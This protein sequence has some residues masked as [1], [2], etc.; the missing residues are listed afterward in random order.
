MSRDCDGTTS[1]MP[2]STMTV[3]GARA[4]R[5]SDNH[6]TENGSDATRGGSS[7]IVSPLRPRPTAGLCRKLSWNPCTL[8][9]TLPRVPSNAVYPV[10]QGLNPKA[11]A[12]GQ[13]PVVP[14][15]A[16]RAAWRDLLPA[17]K[18]VL[19]EARSLHAALRALVGTTAKPC[20]DFMCDSRGLNPSAARRWT[21][22]VLNGRGGCGRIMTNGTHSQATPD[23][24]SLDPAGTTLSRV[25]ALAPAGRRPPRK[26]LQ[27][28]ARA[29]RR[30][31][32]RSTDRRGHGR[33]A[34]G[35]MFQARPPRPFNMP[36]HPDR[37]Q[38]SARQGPCGP[39]AARS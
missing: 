15:K 30:W 24:A 17:T 14:T 39:T 6:D 2:D 31:R 13:F 32:R 29:R 1:A 7:T 21:N 4:V 38:T 33:I 5:R 35:Q 10:A 16:R 11:I 26:L 22:R 27:E 12:Y 36:S 3:N 19:V 34:T 28:G 18:V 25:I 9:T 8:P 20:P 23:R 37:S